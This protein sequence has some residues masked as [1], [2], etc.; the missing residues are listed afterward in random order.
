MNRN[1]LISAALT[2]AAPSVSAQ[3]TGTFFLDVDVASHVILTN[4]R[5]AVSLNDGNNTVSYKAWQNLRIAPAEGYAIESLTAFDAAG[6]QIA[7]NLWWFNAADDSY[8][9]SFSGYNYD[10][11]TFKVV[12]KEYTPQLSSVSVEINDSKAIKDGIYNV[13]NLSVTATDG[14]SEIKYD[15][16]KGNRFSLTLVRSVT[17]ASVSLNGATQ[18]G[19]FNGLGELVYGFTINPGDEISIN[20]SLEDPAFTLT[21]DNADA[22]I[23]TFPD[24]S[25]ILAGLIDGAN[26]LKYSIGDVM[27]VKAADGYRIVAAE[28]L[29]YSSYTD[30]YSYTFKGGESGIVLSVTTEEYNPPTAILDIY[31]EDPSKVSRIVADVVTN[32]FI[33]GLNTVKVNLEKDRHCQIVYR[34]DSAD[35]ISASVDGQPLKI[36]E[37]WQFESEINDL[38][39]RSYLIIIGKPGWMPVEVGIDSVEEQDDNFTV[40]SLDGTVVCRD[41]N[42]TALKS[43]HKGIYV[44]NGKKA[45]IR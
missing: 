14:I 21:L 18:E 11:Y 32:K 16:A 27:T 30:S 25:T 28:G 20:A 17:E 6:V 5:N 13:G 8:S 45:I 37:T 15:S 36:E 34:I 31:I 40:I 43:L 24:E 10:N 38:E 4:N 7:N 9:T 33:E 3:D 22:V 1:I 23:A 19:S 41:A 29:R 2:L 35:E 39:A 44:V 26:H 42:R 12:T